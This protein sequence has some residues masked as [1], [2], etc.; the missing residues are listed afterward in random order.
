MGCGDRRC[1]L[2]I[3]GLS[4]KNSSLHNIRKKICVIP[5]RASLV[6]GSI[7]DNIDINKKYS[8]I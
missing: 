1:K 2:V 6:S 3:D 4:Q 7:K 5:K 8:D